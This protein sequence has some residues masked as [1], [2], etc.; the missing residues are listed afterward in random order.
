MKM[1]GGVMVDMERP[2]ERELANRLPPVPLFSPPEPN[3]PH[4]LVS[5]S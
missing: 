5:N 3:P 4:R 2:S 1:S